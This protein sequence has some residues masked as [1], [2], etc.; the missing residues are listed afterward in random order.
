MIE[1]TVAIITLLL[2]LGAGFA[3][4]YVV[5]RAL[6]QAQ[7]QSAEAKAEK[8]LN[9]AKNKQQEVLMRAKEKGIKILEDAKNEE[10]ERRQELRSIQ[11]RLEKREGMFDQKIIEFQE[12]QQKLQDKTK[13]IEEIR[14][15]IETI[16]EQQVATLEKVA[17]MSR[18]EAQEHLFQRAAKE[19]GDDLAARIMKLER[20]SS[21]EYEKKAK[22]I[23]T[24]VIQ[25]VASS[26]ASDVTSA[27]VQLPSDEMKGRII[28]KEGRNI[29]TVERITGCDLVVDDTPEIITVSSFSPIRRQVARIALEKLIKDG[30]IQPARI[31]SFVEDAKKELALD[32]KK[33]AEEALY[34]MG[35]TGLDPKLVMIIGRLKYRYSYGQ[36]NLLHAKEV[37]HISALLAEEL[38]ADSA[39]AKKAGLL[40]DIGKALDHE[41]EGGHPEIGYRILKKFGLPE[42]IAHCCIEHHE[43]KPKTLL[44]AIV[45]AADAISSS[46]PGA[47]RDSYEEY[48]TR[49]QDLENIATSFPGTDKAYA[50]Q[51]G[52]EVRVFVNPNDIDDYEAYNLAKDVARK[53]EQEMQY[54]GEIKVAVIRE[55]RVIEYAK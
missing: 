14:G 46:R 18:E 2:V 3:V 7:T 5:R 50:I 31:E 20:E 44:G 4:G 53:I 16:K 42:E 24:D 33:S 45:K 25:R 34:E 22:Q 41:T 19:A 43:D 26:H 37:G 10:K 27:V 23:L 39:A 21:E 12:K 52:R 29:K 17:A 32:L 28:G 54:P 6:A 36:N 8:M 51:A 15:K 9:E 48:I 49:L 1:N 47:R 55:T 35:I 30:R 38:G 40:H 11:T 13:Q